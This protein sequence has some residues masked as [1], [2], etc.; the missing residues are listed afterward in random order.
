MKKTTSRHNILNLFKKQRIFNEP[1]KEKHTQKRQNNSRLQTG[2]NTHQSKATSDLMK[3]KK[4]S[5]Q[6]R[7]PAKPSPKMN[8]I[9]AFL[10]MKAS[11]IIGRLAL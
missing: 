4:K 2:N 3:K 10:Y 11:R 8:E 7:H 6:F 1:G 9:K 5:Y